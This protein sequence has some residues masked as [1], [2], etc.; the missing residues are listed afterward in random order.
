[1]ENLDYNYSFDELYLHSLPL[2]EDVERE[3]AAGNFDTVRKKIAYLQSCEKVP[4]CM[5]KRLSI[6]LDVLSHIEAR[7]SVP[8][9]RALEEAR[10]VLPE[11]TEEELE[12]FRL[13]GQPDWRYINGEVH[14]LDSFAASLGKLVPS[15][16]EPDNLDALLPTLSDG[17]VMSTHIHIRHELSLDEDIV[18]PGKTLRVH[19]PLPKEGQNEQVYNL[20]LLK[21]SFE[22]KHVCE[23]DTLQPTVYFEEKAEPGQV[24]SIEYELD[25]K[26]TYMDMS[27]VDL[28]AVTASDF[29]SA[30]DLYLRERLPH[31]AF[32]PFLKAL[33]L[34]IKGEETNPLL[35]A[36][37]MYDYVTTK[38]MYRFA[39]NYASIPCVSEYCAMNGKGDCGIQTLLFITLCRICGIPAGWQSGLCAEPGM[40]GKPGDVGEHD[41]AR[42]YIPSIGW[43]HADLSMGG[44]AY[45]RGDMARWN[46]FFGNMDTY[47]IPINDEVQEELYPPRKFARF[48]PCDNQ[49]G[50]AEYE[51]MIIS[52]TKINTK[53]TD[54]GT[55]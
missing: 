12:K 35:I 32:T 4:L 53:F 55:K 27:K 31:I 52:P 21:T 2:P 28:A 11:I 19:L 49:D 14:Y 16:Y 41:W 46:F 22:P 44:S 13:E 24:F 17:D 38:I 18:I 5:K 20:K 8:A 42:F 25:H 6:E 45:R 37:K 3:K 54:L 33:A 29:P 48:D 50:E 9:S 40:E 1:M 23:G 7:F 47:R 34:E 15:E 26:L 36:R 39:P 30:C 43:R 10:K 51:D